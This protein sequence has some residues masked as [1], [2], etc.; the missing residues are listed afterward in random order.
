MRGGAFL[1]NVASCG[2]PVGAY[3]VGYDLGY[4]TRLLI[5]CSDVIVR[6]YESK[7]AGETLGWATSDAKEKSGVHIERNLALPHPL[8]PLP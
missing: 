1:L 7:T 5:G 2:G 6:W 8:F 3:G 4:V